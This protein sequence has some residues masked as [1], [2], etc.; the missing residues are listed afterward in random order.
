MPFVGIVVAVRLLH[1]IALT[2]R[3]DEVYSPSDGTGELKIPK[4]KNITQF[5]YCSTGDSPSEV[6]EFLA[7]NQGSIRTI[8]I[9]NLNWTFPSQVIS[10]RNL[11]HLDFLGTFPADS[12]ALN[13]ILNDGHQ[14]ES[15][16]LK[17][18]LECTAS[19]AFRDNLN[20]LPFLK[21]FS[22]C[23]LGYRVNDA[24]L[25]PAISE[26][27]R[28]RVDLHML[29][30]TVPSAEYAHKRLG[31]DANVWGVLPSLVNLR[32]LSATLP[33]DVAAAVAMWLVPRSV[34][35]LTLHSIPSNDVLGYVSV[36]SKELFFAD[37]THTQSNSNFAPAYHQP[38]S[39]LDSLKPAS[40]T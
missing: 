1:T 27:L 7:R 24:D 25:F 34:Q 10:I 32:S 17:C 22:L 13:A 36:S 8:H 37:L 28:G 26:F 4:F 39:S 31:Y 15:L 14:L 29:Q 5:A 3:S 30:L 35:S 9:Q 6:N 38:S 12:P 2:Q 19:V 18:V 11:T 33:K 40:P 21:H 23:L 16:R 20:A